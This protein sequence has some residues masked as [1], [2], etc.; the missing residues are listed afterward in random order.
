MSRALHSKQL[1][2]LSDQSQPRPPHPQRLH[3]LHHLHLSGQGFQTGTQADPLKVKRTRQSGAECNA[4]CKMGAFYNFTDL[5]S[6][7][8][9]NLCMASDHKRAISGSRTTSAPLS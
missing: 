5:P 4:E 1:A 6:G 9:L 3:Q 2:P 8:Y 7:V